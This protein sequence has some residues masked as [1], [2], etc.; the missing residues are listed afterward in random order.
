MNYVPKG[1]ERGERKLREQQIR[2][3]NDHEIN[4]ERRRRSFT[5]TRAGPV[6]SENGSKRKRD[7]PVDKSV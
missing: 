7:M 1:G 5:G 3:T 2:K 4:G 6:P